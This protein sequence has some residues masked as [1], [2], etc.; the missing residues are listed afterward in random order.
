MNVPLAGFHNPAAWEQ[1]PNAR[2]SPTARDIFDVLQGRQE[3]RG[4]VRITQ[5]ELATRLNTTQSAISRAMSELRDTGLIHARTRHGQILIHP[6]YAGYESLAHMVNHI[7]D[8]DTHLWPLAFPAS[9]IRP[10]RRCDPHPTPDGD[11]GEPAP[12]PAPRPHLHLA[13]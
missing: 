12:T 3:P 10:P 6:L 2:L 5:N 1:L 7:Q 11:G 4:H 13:G 9:D 8:P